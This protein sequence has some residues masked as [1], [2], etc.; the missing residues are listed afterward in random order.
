MSRC[1]G[2][3]PAPRDA[4]GVLDHRSAVA[5][6]ALAVKGRLRE[7]PL[8]APVLALARQ[9]PFAEKTLGTLQRAAL[10]EAFVV[11]DEDVADEFGVVDEEEVLRPTRKRLTSP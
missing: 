1:V 7:A 8:P 2:V 10:D 9:Q 6:D 5:R 4:R 3:A 11:R